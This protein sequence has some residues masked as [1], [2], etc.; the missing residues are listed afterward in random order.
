LDV[1]SFRMMY[2]TPQLLDEHIWVPVRDLFIQQC[3]HSGYRVLEGI[4]D[5]LY[6]PLALRDAAER[7]LPVTFS[8]FQALDPVGSV[9]GSWRDL[10]I[11]AG[12]PSPI[13]RREALA[14]REAAR[15]ALLVQQNQVGIA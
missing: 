4:V 6:P 9:P 14:A 8:N 15:Q 10:A 3:C 2:S 5:S 12:R 11:R 13:L 1:F 7:G